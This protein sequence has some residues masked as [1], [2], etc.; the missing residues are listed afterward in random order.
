MFDLFVS[1]NKA[2]LKD[3]ASYLPDPF[4][5]SVNALDMQ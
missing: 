4:A 2:K 5:H 3:Y 1:K